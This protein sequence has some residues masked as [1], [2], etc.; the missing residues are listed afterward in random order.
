[1][2]EKNGESEMALKMSVKFKICGWEESVIKPSIAGG[3]PLPNMIYSSVNLYLL[4]VTYTWLPSS[5]SSLVY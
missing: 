3:H 1:M 2:S 4:R 5:D